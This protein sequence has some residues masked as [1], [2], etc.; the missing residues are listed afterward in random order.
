MSYTRAVTR[1]GRGTTYTTAPVCRLR[2]Q[3]VPARHGLEA[4]PSR[5]RAGCCARYSARR[6]VRGLWTSSAAGRARCRRRGRLLSI[7]LAVGIHDQTESANSGVTFDGIE[8]RSRDG[9][10]VAR[11]LNVQRRR[12]KQTKSRL[13]Q[14]ASCNDARVLA[15]APKWILYGLGTRACMVL[16][17]QDCASR[18]ECRVEGWDGIGTNP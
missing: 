1:D 3:S 15:S 14:R 7:A 16:G 13:F 8:Q 9:G 18:P 5:P 4:A 10:G 6:H 2:I 11:M 12:C 17:T